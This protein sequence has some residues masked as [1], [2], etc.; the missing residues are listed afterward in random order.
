L[1]FK[2]G[3]FSDLD[4]DMDFK[5]KYRIGFG[6]EKPKSVHLYQLVRSWES[7]ACLQLCSGSPVGRWWMPSS[8]LIS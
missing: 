6:F 3:Q 8:F 4:L 5:M 1:D 7:L 2:S